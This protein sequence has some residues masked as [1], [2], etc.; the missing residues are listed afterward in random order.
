MALD[1][2]VNHLC[3]S[4]ALNNSEILEKKTDNTFKGIMSCCI[5]FVSAAQQKHNS[6]ILEA[7][8]LSCDKLLA[9]KVT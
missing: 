6:M 8:A 1:G 9:K 3:L 7:L 4:I 2:G 5:S